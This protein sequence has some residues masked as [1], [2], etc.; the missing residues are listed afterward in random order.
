MTKPR[1]ILF[2]FLFSSIAAAQPIEISESGLPEGVHLLKAS[3]Q[4]DCIVE[5]GLFAFARDQPDRGEP[6]HP[7]YLCRVGLDDGSFQVIGKLEGTPLSLDVKGNRVVVVSKGSDR[8]HSLLY[9][10]SLERDSKIHR[11]LVVE[12]RNLSVRIVGTKQ[13][14]LNG[15]FLSENGKPEPGANLVNLADG[16]VEKRVRGFPTAAHG[17]VIGKEMVLGHSYPGGVIHLDLETGEFTSHGSSSAWVYQGVHFGDHVYFRLIG[18]RLIRYSI[19]PF[20]KSKLPADL[21]TEGEYCQQLFLDS[22]KNEL[23]ICDSG[24]RISSIDS[25]DVVTTIKKAELPKHR[26]WFGVWNR[27]V[28]IRNDQ[29]IVLVPLLGK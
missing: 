3:D 26:E 8:N 28:I 20:G 14:I 1:S 22:A 12:G 29:G 19:K 23:F 24:S 9:E 10:L 27:Q 17:F 18:D 13:V 11:K 21:S 5:G 4:P 15:F 16:S 25:N 6:T 2:V 7:F